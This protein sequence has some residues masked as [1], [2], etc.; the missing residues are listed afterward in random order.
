MQENCTSKASRKDEQQIPVKFA[1]TCNVL[2]NSDSLL[3]QR[4]LCR[5]S[6]GLIV[7]TTG[8]GKSVFA[9]QFAA[10]LAVGIDLFGIK[11]PNN[12]PLKVILVQA[13]NDPLELGEVLQ[14]IT[15]D[16]ETPAK[17]LLNENLVMYYVWQYSDLKFIN[18]LDAVVDEHEADLVIVDPLMAYAGRDLNDNASVADFLRNHVNR[19][20]KSRSRTKQFGLLFVHYTGKGNISKKNTEKSTASLIYDVLGA[21]EIANW[22]R[23]IIRIDRTDEPGGDENKYLLTIPKR[24]RRSGITRPKKQDAWACDIYYAHQP[25][26]V[27]DEGKATAP[28]LRWGSVPTEQQEERS[29]STDETPRFQPTS[30]NKTDCKAIL[31]QGQMDTVTTT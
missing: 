6:G 17:T 5:G 18:W 4:F 8:V 19:L 27:D 9:T 23:C 22:A 11:H 24:G 1:L 25:P 2:D 26:Q 30:K 16:W 3:G 28:I 12:K 21:S 7:G 14:S 20:L 29:E 13:E 10:H 31:D 15:A